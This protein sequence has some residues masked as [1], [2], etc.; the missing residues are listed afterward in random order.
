MLYLMKRNADL[1][2]NCSKS[3][4][5]PFLEDEV[6][7]CTNINGGMCHIEFYIEASTKCI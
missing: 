2:F 1:Q 6:L 3:Y 7:D 4:A 5:F